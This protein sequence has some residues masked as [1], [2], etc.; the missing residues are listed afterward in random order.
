ML[1]FGDWEERRRYVAA[2][3]KR[4]NLN[5]RILD[6]VAKHAIIPLLKAIEEAATENPD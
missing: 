1:Y 5:Q 2:E 4:L 3:V 6:D